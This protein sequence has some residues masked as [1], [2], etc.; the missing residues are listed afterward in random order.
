LTGVVKIGIEWEGQWGPH[1]ITHEKL[2]GVT[3][4]PN[5]F[6]LIS[7]EIAR[8]PG[9]FTASVKAQFEE[10]GVLIGED[11]SVTKKPEP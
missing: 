8:D 7:T 5:L 2:A 9:M 3:V 4:G 6:N 10:A 11:G 1:Q